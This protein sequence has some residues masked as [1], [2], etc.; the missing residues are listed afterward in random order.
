MATAYVSGAAAL[1]Q[2]FRRHIGKVL[3]QPADLKQAIMSSARNLP[4]SVSGRNDEFGD[5]CLDMNRLLD[6]VQQM[7]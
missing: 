4:Q 2:A 1:A 6:T 3:L 5:G 7:P